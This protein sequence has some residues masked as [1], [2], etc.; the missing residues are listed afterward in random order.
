VFL[1][2]FSEI[3]RCAY[4]LE[5][6][7]NYYNTYRKLMEHFKSLMPGYIFDVSYED[8]VQDF[9]Q[10]I[11]GVADFCGLEWTDDFLDFHTNERSILSPSFTQISQPLYSS[12]LDF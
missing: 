6:I 1:V 7:S 10:T 8:V 5:N 9:E 2:I 3:Q 11:R 12:S 4:K